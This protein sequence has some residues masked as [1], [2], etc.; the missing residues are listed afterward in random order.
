MAVGTTHQPVARSAWSAPGDA[1]RPAVSGAWWRLPDEQ[2]HASVSAVVDAIAK[3]NSQRDAD[4]EAYRAL[5]RSNRNSY[6][7]APRGQRSGRPPPRGRLVLNVVASCVDTATSKVAKVKPKA[8]FLTDAGSGSQQRR[9]KRLTTYVEGV[10]LDAGVYREAHDA[11]LDAA[12]VGTGCVRLHWGEDAKG[13]PRLL[14]ERV[15][16]LEIHVDAEDGHYGKPRQLH[17]VR[18]VYPEVLEELFPEK[19]AE[20][21]LA[22][23]KSDGKPRDSKLG[24]GRVR[25]VESFHLPSG[26][27]AKDGKRS[28]VV[29]GCTL[30]SEP[31]ECDYFPYAFFHWKRDEG[32]WGVG[33]AQE[34]EDIQQEITATAANIQRAHHLVAL[35]RVFVE[36]GSQV[37][38]SQLGNHRDRV[39]VVKYVGRPPVFQTAT[40]MNPEAYQYLETLIARA[41][42]LVGVSQ[43]QAAARK[44]PGVDAA[45]AMREMNDIASDR[46][47]TTLQR[48]EDFHMDLARKAVDMSRRKYRDGA[49]K[50]SAKAADSRYVRSIAWKDVDLEDDKF[51]LKAWPVNQ[52]PSTPTGKLQ[53][54]QEYVQAGFLD[55]EAAMQLLDFPDL[56][57]HMTL[58]QAANEDVLRTI[59]GILEDGEPGDVDDVT[60]LNLALSVG[61]QALLRAKWSEPEDRVELL[62]RWVER[63]KDRAQPAAPDPQADPAAQ[64]AGQAGAVASAPPPMAPAA[65]PEAPPTS[66]LLAVSDERAKFGVSVAGSDGPY[67]VHRGG[68]MDVMGSLRKHSDEATKYQRDP[69]GGMMMTAYSDERGKADLDAASSEPAAAMDAIGGGKSWRYAPDVP[70]ED[71]TRVNY[72]TTT[73]DLKKTDLGRAMVTVDEATGYEA[74]DLKHAVSSLLAMAGNLNKRLRALEGSEPIEEPTPAEEQGADRRG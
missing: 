19:R 6:V 56:D 32:F 61:M 58:A 34:L 42:E 63:V 49:K 22:A 65:V 35:P 48:W 66:D 28:I 43:M 45:V 55:R 3:D 18:W 17:H 10:F 15:D 60:D 33:I 1:S 27:S 59:E 23:G 73:E 2:L 47:A 38:T 37:V 5:Y 29:E 30:F 36:Q 31:W 72:G 50:L 13:D 64:A 11:F 69:S 70:G 57:G 7:R 67:D 71:P 41:Y 20:I 74:I 62:R 40:A 16:P 4:W 24:E 8:R 9:A 44:E 14:A 54:V 52:L 68:G 46:F 26:P 25:V 53:A 21:R 51:Q 39:P 12:K